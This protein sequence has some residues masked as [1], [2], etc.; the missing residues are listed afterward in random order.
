MKVRDPFSTT[1]NI[2]LCKF[3]Y[4][5]LKNHVIYL[6]ELAF[7][8]AWLITN[9]ALVKRQSICLKLKCIPLCFWHMQGTNYILSCTVAYF[10]ECYQLMKIIETSW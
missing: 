6:F 4:K 1:Q 9:I 8:F 10:V 7:R 3:C 5:E 2:F